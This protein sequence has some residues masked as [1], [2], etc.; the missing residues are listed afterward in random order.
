MVEAGVDD[1]NRAVDSA[2]RAFDSPDWVEMTAKVRAKLMMRLADLVAEDAPCTINWYLIT[3]HCYSVKCKRNHF[4]RSE[5]NEAKSD[6]VGE[7][8]WFCY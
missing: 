6:F 1:L 4:E 8:E 7:I 3:D 5:V 2:A